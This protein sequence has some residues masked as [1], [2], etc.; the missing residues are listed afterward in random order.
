MPQASNVAMPFIKVFSVVALVVSGYMLF[1]SLIITAIIFSLDGHDLVSHG[2]RSGA[3][4]FLSEN[5]EAVFLGYILYSSAAFLS[6]FGLRRGKR[7]SY[8]AWIVLLATVIAWGILGASI[9]FYSLLSA[10]LSTRLG[11][12]TWATPI[13]VIV[14]SLSGSVF[15]A[16]LLRQLLKHYPSQDSA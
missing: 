1:I 13:I 6:A 14:S 12:L 7:W 5:L 10:G 15:F 16:W 3:Q 11:A 8:W 4:L 2:A 9:E